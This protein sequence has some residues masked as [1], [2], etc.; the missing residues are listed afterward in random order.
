MH[1]QYKNLRNFVV[2]VVLLATLA[3]CKK[4]FLEILPKGRIIASK[5]TDYDLMLNNLD[6]INNNGDGHAILGDEIAAVEP[7][8][9]GAAYRERQLFKYEGDLY[10]AEDSK[11]TLAP[12]KAL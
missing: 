1:K 10:T 7:F 8:F 9:A 6:L 12:L 3:S 11:E 2:V 4:S 5:T